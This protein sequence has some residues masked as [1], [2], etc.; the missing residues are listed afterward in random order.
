M[1]ERLAAGEDT[2]GRRRRRAQRWAPAG[3]SLVELA[4]VLP[5]AAL[6]LIGTIDLGRAFQ[7]YVDL[8]NAVRQGAMFGTVFPAQ[9][10]SAAAADP[11]NIVWQ[12]QHEGGLAIGSGDI[13]V[14]CYQ[15]PAMDSTTLRGTGDC[16]RASGVASGDLIEVSARYAFRPLTTQLVAILPSHFTM[17]KVMRMVIQ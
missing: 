1:S 13:V 17:R 9:V 8:T 4:L 6:I 12:V 5:V 10:A 11:D 2:Q 3:Q 14:R 7:Q 16:S 15:G